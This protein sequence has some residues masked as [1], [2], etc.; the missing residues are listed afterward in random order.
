MSR[1]GKDKLVSLRFSLS[2]RFSALSWRHFVGLPRKVHLSI[3]S[4]HF[5]LP[6]L[7]FLRG[8]F[9]Q[10]LVWASFKFF[11]S[12]IPETELVQTQF[13]GVFLFVAQDSDSSSRRAAHVDSKDGSSSLHIVLF[14]PWE[15][16][17]LHGRVYFIA[18]LADP[19]CAEIVWIDLSIIRGS[20]KR[21]NA[22]F[23]M[24]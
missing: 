24:I 4:P 15:P 11:F 16:K 21:G 13:E 22:A 18:H 3:I 23:G 19:S 1:E 7:S 9:F 8:F 14:D 6:S 2:L 20:T 12:S 5:P 10:A 17:V